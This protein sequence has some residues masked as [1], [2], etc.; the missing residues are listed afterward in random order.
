MGNKTSFKNLKE[1]FYDGTTKYFVIPNYQ[2]GYKWAVKRKGEEFS[3]VEKLLHDLQIASRR[4]DKYFIQGVTVVEEN[5]RV[6]LI[7]GQQRTTTLYLLLYC[8]DPSNI[9]EINL[10][11]E[12]RKESKLFINM[13]KDFAFD[14]FG[15]GFAGQDIHYFREAIKQIQNLL[16]EI[17]RESFLV[18]LL[19]KVTL[20]YI[21][22]DKDKATKTFTMMNGAKATMQQEELIKA[23]F[24]RCV[25]IPKYPIDIAISNI[26][27]QHD[28]LARDWDINTLRSRYAREWDKWLYWWNQKNTKTYFGTEKLPFLGLLLPYFF[29]YHARLLP[30]SQKEVKLDNFKFLIKENVSTLPKHIFKKLRDLQKSFEDIYS[31]PK[32]YN[33]LKLA[34]LCAQGTEDKL[35]LIKYFIENKQ[36][37]ALLEEYAKWRLIG[38]SHKDIVSENESNLESNPKVREALLVLNKLSS[39][40]VYHE[41]YDLALKQLLRLNVMECTKLA[42]GNGEKFDFSI[43]DKKSLEHIHPKSKV[44]H[45]KQ[46]EESLRKSYLNGNNIEIDL[47]NIDQNW[48][49]RDELFDCTEH[50]IGNLVLLDKNENSKFNDKPFHD[51]KNIYFNI[52]EVFKS[53]N[54]LHT[55]TIF[56]KSTWGKE[57]IEVNQKVF[58]NK[59][60][61]DY[62]INFIPSNNEL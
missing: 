11:Y 43:Y 9:Q 7:D 6:I 26:D 27:L 41:H 50:S 56:S 17:N 13:L 37:L 19:N 55:I 2:R 53:R 52:N 22:I 58:I 28:L 47:T 61:K 60:I 32:T 33:S 18:F 24:L 40:M 51:K 25:S 4:D 3:A 48:L 54:L 21:I 23:E 16:A 1:Y 30:D 42:D 8:L 59:F 45:F 39:K 10:D 31:V 5:N 62:N 46:D 35:Q 12:I 20:L 14:P 49:N 29:K 34:M 15:D 38:L 36:D 44:Y 57:G